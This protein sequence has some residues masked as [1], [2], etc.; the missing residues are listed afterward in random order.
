MNRKTIWIVLIVVG[1]CLSGIAGAYVGS[2]TIAKSLLMS[3]L[4]TS[5]TSLNSNLKVIELLK[6]NEKEKAEELLENLI[7]VD[8]SS[9]GVHAGNK[10]FT[11]NRNE[12]I[13]AIHRA[14]AF[15]SKWPNASHTIN[16]NLRNGVEA[17]FK[18]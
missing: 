14:K 9:M 8:V 10:F 15:R 17:A 7:D 1:F 5:V 12:I 18:L 4:G 13:E 2:N 11:Q 3:E 16:P 6:K